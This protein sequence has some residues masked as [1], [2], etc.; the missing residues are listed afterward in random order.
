M[1]IRCF[2]NFTKSIFFH[3][4]QKAACRRENIFK[5][6]LFLEHVIIALSSTKLHV[7]IV[8]FDCSKS[9]RKLDQRNSGGNNSNRS[10]E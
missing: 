6:Y 8:D 4:M 2:E 10:S 7:K 5:F 3:G 1:Y 9:E